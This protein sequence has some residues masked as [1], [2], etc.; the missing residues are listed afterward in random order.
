MPDRDGVVPIP[1]GRG[2]TTAFAVA[3]GDAVGL[4]DA[5]LPRS[6][7]AVLAAL[8]RHGLEEPR[9]ILATHLHADH[10]GGMRAVHDHTGAPVMAH[11]AE[12][13]YIDGRRRPPQYTN[14]GTGRLLRRAERFLRVDPVPVARE[15]SDGDTLEFPEELVVLHLP[16]HT[17]GH[18]GLWW[19][20]RR[21]LVAGDAVMRFAGR[22]VLGWPNDT[23][24]PDAARESAERIASFKPEV[25]HMAHGKPLTPEEALGLTEAREGRFRHFLP[26]PFS[27]P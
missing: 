3:S 6:G 23:Q 9:W 11:A 18:V 19:P 21:T 20:E 27:R 17:A 7:P 14:R 12:A 16:G 13:P 2:F 10:V 24:D 4:V 26:A 25:V 5:G 8:H 15:L 1:L 22:V